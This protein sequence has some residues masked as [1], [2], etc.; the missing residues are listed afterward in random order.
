MAGELPFNDLTAASRQ[1]YGRYPLR[2]WFWGPGGLLG[3]IKWDAVERNRREIAADAE[4]IWRENCWSYYGDILN[5]EWNRRAHQ[6]D[7]S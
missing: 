5:E 7:R 3:A 2:E 4:R 1:A 6:E